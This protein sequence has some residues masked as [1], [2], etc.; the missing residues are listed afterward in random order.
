MIN[1][2]RAEDAF[3][4]TERSSSRFSLEINKVNKPINKGSSASE[5][6][7]VYRAMMPNKIKNM[8]IY[9]MAG[10]IFIRFVGINIKSKAS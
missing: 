3:T 5:D 4:A 7:V 8:L 10:F 6:L 1:A 9:F 2:Y